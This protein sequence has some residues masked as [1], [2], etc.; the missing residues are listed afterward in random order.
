[1]YETTVFYIQNKNETYTFARFLKYRL[2]LGW[3]Q[4]D[5]WVI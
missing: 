2:F 5:L 3:Y 1:M 4:K